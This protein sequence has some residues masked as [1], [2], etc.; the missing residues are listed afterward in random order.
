MEGGDYNTFFPAA[1]CC[2]PFQ[3][4]LYMAAH[5]KPVMLVKFSTW[6]LL[7]TNMCEQ[8]I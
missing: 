8:H 2:I 4:P 6:F 7:P 3:P 5:S 1:Y